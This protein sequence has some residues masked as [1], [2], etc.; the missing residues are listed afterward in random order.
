MAEK[1]KCD[2]GITFRSEEG[3]THCN[4][5][6][7]KLS[8]IGKEKPSYLAKEDK[9]NMDTKLQSH[10]VSYK[11]QILYTLWLFLPIVFTLWQ[12]K[13]VT[14]S[15]SYDFFSLIISKYRE[16]LLSHLLFWYAIG[17]VVYL[18]IKIWTQNHKTVT[19]QRK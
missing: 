8:D 3:Q 17:G 15:G 4:Y 6:G 14:L 2:C 5:C 9:T 13:E 11:K 7:I 12:T 19:P 16:V 18:L 1:I 10:T